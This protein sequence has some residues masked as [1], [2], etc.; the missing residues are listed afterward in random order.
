AYVDGGGTLVL[1]PRTSV[2][3]RFNV[4]PERALPAWLDG[5]CGVR[6]LDYQSVVGDGEIPLEGPS[7]KGEFRGWYEELEL[8]GAQALASYSGGVF[9]GSPAVAERRVGEGRALYVGGA[10]TL[11]TLERLYRLLGGQLELSMLE[12]PQGL[13]VVPLEGTGDGEL[14]V[15][16]NHSDRE[17]RLASK[18]RRWHDHLT[19]AGGGGAFAIGPYGVAVLEVVQ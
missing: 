5:L 11:P 7:F 8:D 9:A 2:K 16:L 13:E 14:M 6:V 1:A 18:G 4:T 19:G 12:V 15:L 10:A 3:D 17:Q